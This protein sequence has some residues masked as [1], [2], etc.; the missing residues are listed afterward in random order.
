MSDKEI[1]EM[2]MNL[3]KANLD[4]FQEVRQEDKSYILGYL[5]GLTKATIIYKNKM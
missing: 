5:A 1:L 2:K 4:L 3:L